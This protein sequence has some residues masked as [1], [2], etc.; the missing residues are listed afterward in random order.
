M[1]PEVAGDP[2]IR[3]NRFD[4]HHVVR[5]IGSHRHRW[6]E[7]LY[8]ERGDGTHLVG[9]RPFEVSAGALFLIAPGETHDARGMANSEGWI[10]MISPEALNP[11]DRVSGATSLLAA[12]LLLLPFLRGAPWW[13]S[14][15]S[16]F[17][18]LHGGPPGSDRARPAGAVLGSLQPASRHFTILPDQRSNWSACFRRLDRE[19]RAR[20][21]GY[22]RAVG[23]LSTLL[24]VDTARLAASILE[25]PAGA[26][27]PL[28]GRTFEVIDA[29]Y[30][31]GISLSDVAVAVGRSP[32]YLTTLMRRTTGR[33][34]VEWIVERRMLEARR[35]L[36]ETDLTIAEIGRNVGYGHR[37][38]FVRSFRR[39]HG[40]SP[41]AW[42]AARP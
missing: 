5:H 30:A 20:P 3:V 27:T 17:D 11:G 29:R 34:V 24:L 8:I 7:L 37:A 38:H 12:P 10:L 6:L 16:E 36:L 39:M 41:L 4:R 33:T 13:G 25:E 14:G 18:A 32:A 21:P 22:Q 19:L 31:D 35:L 26:R 15:E 2:P 9:N 42:R 40:M 23:A 1:S 28:V